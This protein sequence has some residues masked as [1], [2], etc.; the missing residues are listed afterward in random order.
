MLILQ[1]ERIQE[2]RRARGMG[3]TK[4]AK[5]SGLTERQIAR[6]EGALP[7][8][9]ELSS[10][11]ALRLAAALQVEPETLLGDQPLTEADKAARPKTTSCSCCN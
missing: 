6:L 10:D 5:I 4:L 1:P 9:G 2:L 3:R 7:W 11:M 8:R